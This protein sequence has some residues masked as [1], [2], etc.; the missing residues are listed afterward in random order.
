MGGHRRGR[1]GKVGVTETVSMPLEAWMAVSMVLLLVPLALAMVLAAT[2]ASPGHRH[3][4]P[5][6]VAVRTGR[7]TQRP[8]RA[9]T[10]C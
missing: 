3:R 2:G 10:S 8:R 5:R 1:V 7:R 9:R 4:S 6:P